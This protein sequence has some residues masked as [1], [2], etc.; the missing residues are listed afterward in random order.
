MVKFIM[1]DNWK[2]YSVN[3]SSEMLFNPDSTNFSLIDRNV[4]YSFPRDWVEFD[5]ELSLL[6]YGDVEDSLSYFLS[7]FQVV[8]LTDGNLFAVNK[9]YGIEIPSQGDLEVRIMD[10]EFNLIK[11]TIVYFE[12][13][14]YLAVHI[15]CS[16]CGS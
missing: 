14:K 12:E 11:D 13:N 15:W 6:D 16:V 5:N 8:R 9:S 10:N 7:P 1:Y 4:E 3:G 2:N